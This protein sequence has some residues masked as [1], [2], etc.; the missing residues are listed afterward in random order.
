VLDLLNYLRE[1]GGGGK[2]VRRG[3]DSDPSQ[4]IFYRGNRRDRSL[5]RIKVYI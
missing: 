3:E 5:N 1:D 2:N 4:L